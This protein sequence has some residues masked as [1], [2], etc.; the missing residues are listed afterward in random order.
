[1]LE[2]HSAAMHLGQL[3]PRLVLILLRLQVLVMHHGLQPVV[4]VA[5]GVIGAA[6][7]PLRN[8][9]PAVAGRQAGRQASVRRH[10]PRCWL[11][12]GPLVAKFRGYVHKLTGLNP[13]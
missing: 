1:M 9:V 3:R 10:V 2:A 11:R 6:G 12:R 7:Q 13:S 5:D 8:L 4:P